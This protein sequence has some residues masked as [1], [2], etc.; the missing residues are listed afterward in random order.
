MDSCASNLNL[1]TDE[2]AD[3]ESINMEF[4]D[5]I[6]RI[7]CSRVSCSRYMHYTSHHAFKRP[8]VLE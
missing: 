7:M 1:L 4:I 6:S 2:K 5:L 3:P 8:L